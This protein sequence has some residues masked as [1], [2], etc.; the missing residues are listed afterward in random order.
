MYSLTIYSILHALAA[1][2]PLPQDVTSTV[3]PSTEASGLITFISGVLTTPYQ[4]GSY[5]S[6]NVCA[7]GYSCVDGKCVSSTEIDPSTY[8]DSGATSQDLVVESPVPVADTPVAS[9]PVYVPPPT[10]EPIYVPPSTPEPIYVPPSTPETAYVPPPPPRPLS[11]GATLT[12]Y[13]PSTGPAFCDE[14]TYSSSSYV[15]ALSTNILENHCGQTV[16]ITWGGNSVQATVVDQCNVSHGCRVGNI[17]TTAAVW[18]ALGA[19]MDSGVIDV[20]YHF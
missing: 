16:T 1:A 20:Q 13:E 8:T 4:C 18:R 11:S 10:P 7:T 6:N 9:E 12:F 2:V 17:D 19:N 3:T 14:V 15:V 5:A